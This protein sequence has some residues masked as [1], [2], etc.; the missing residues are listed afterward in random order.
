MVL[1]P[2]QQLYLYSPAGT[3]IAGM[4]FLSTFRMML[5]CTEEVGLHFHPSIRWLHYETSFETVTP[6]SKTGI[7]CR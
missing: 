4:T 3:Q 5:S 6:R 7:I 1:Q 2:H